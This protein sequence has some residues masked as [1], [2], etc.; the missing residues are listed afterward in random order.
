MAV[1]RLVEKKGFRYLLEACHLLQQ[2]GMEFRCR[3]IGTGDQE[4]QLSSQIQTLELGRHVSLVGARSH[5]AVMDE[6]RGCRLAVLPCIVGRDG[7]RDALPTVLLE[8]MALS[9]PVVSTD[10]QG[11]DEI[12]DDSENGFLVPQRDSSSLARAIGKLLSDRR[13]SRALGKAGREKA[14][15]LF[16]LRRN[17]AQLREFISLSSHSVSGQLEATAERCV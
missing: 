6:L 16:D 12:V 4:E 2:Q 7:N 13:L 5:Q 9:K 3:I 10:L 1:G 14:E 8:A 15:R 17:V 11:V